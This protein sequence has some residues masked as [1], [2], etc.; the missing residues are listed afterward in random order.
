MVA[1]DGDG[2]NGGDGGRESVRGD[3]VRERVMHRVRE[4]VLYRVRERERE[5]ESFVMYHC[6]LNIF[7][8]S[9]D[10]PIPGFFLI[11]LVLFVW[12]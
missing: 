12:F 2:W 1:G 4:R 5:S 3:K 10:P 11:L 6:L 7:A 9:H 8:L